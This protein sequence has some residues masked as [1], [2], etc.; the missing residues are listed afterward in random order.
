MHKL[1]LSN[2]V[3][4]TAL[5][6]WVLEGQGA[7]LRA[8]NVCHAKDLKINLMLAYCHCVFQ[9]LNFFPLWSSNTYGQY[10]SAEI[11]CSH[12]ENG[13]KL[14]LIKK[15]R[16]K[17]CR[18]EIFHYIFVS[19]PLKKIYI[20]MLYSEMADLKSKYEY[21]KEHPFCS[22]LSHSLPLAFLSSSRWEQGIQHK[23]GTLS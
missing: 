16:L 12:I 14:I 9:C 21:M 5:S 13:L 11:H 7:C 3:L 22:L 17:T 18:P 2:L 4:T 8:N 19:F 6:E 15:L 23:K 20:A 10:N 1:W